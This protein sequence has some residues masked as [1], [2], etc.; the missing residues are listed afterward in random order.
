MA[1][2]RTL[3]GRLPS[4]YGIAAVLVV[5]CGIFSIA[6]LAE[7]QPEGAPAGEELARRI[8]DRHPSGKVVIV[9]G[10]G[11]ADAQFADALRSSLERAGVTVL[12]TCQGPPSAA[13]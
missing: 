10:T 4:E 7:Q 2:N 13:R 5:L 8:A 11:H 9:V 6:T 12:A 3:L 1:T